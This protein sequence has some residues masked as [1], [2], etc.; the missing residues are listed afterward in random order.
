MVPFFPRVKLFLLLGSRRGA[1][2]QCAKILI[3]RSPWQ[4]IK[5]QSCKL[6]A[7]RMN[8]GIEFAIAGIYM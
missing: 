2:R 8:G 4:V 6:H 3:L 1:L 5:G 7:Q